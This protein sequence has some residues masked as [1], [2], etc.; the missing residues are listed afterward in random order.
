MNH[1][2]YQTA[3]LFLLTAIAVFAGT[4]SAQAPKP[5]PTTP[6]VA[7]TKI[8]LID[9]GAFDAKDGLTRY[10]T[11]MDSVDAIFKKEID[12]LRLM[13]EKF[14]ALEKELGTLQQQIQAGGPSAATLQSVYVSKG[15]E[16]E[17][18]GRELKFKQEDIKVRYQNKR[19]EIVGPV[20]DDISAALVEFS[21]QNNFLLLL[22]LSKLDATGTL[23]NL[24]GAEVDVTKQ[25]I[26]FFNARP[27]KT[28]AKK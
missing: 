28:A 22:D 26:Q 12:D 21:K 10:N 1:F 23:L 5:A 4:A 7:P 19:T 11:A 17:K 2:R 20:L 18:L 6:V 14:A 27:P 8:G 3:C 16:Y 15:D 13:N 25:F 9:T 24:P